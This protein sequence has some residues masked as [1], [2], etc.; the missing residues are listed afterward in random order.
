MTTASESQPVAL[1]TPD[2]SGVPLSRRALREQVELHRIRRWGLAVL[3][4][5]LVALVLWSV[6]EANRA[7]L[8]YDFAGCYQAWYLISHGVLGAAGFWKAQG[9]FIIWPLAIFGLLWPHPITLLVIQDLAIV[10]AEAVAFS[11]LTEIIRAR[12]DL[13]FFALV[14]PRAA[15]PRRRPVDLLVGV[16]GLPLGSRWDA[17]RHPRRAG[18]VAWSQARLDLEWPH[19]PFRDGPCHLPGRNRPR[20]AVQAQATLARLHP[21]RR[22]DRLVPR[23]HQARCG[24]NASPDSCRLF[25]RITTSR[26]PVRDRPCH[27]PPPSWVLR[28]RQPGKPLGRHTGERLSE[29]AARLVHRSLCRRRR[30][31]AR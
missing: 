16:L 18:F 3:A 6:L 1:E 11:W 23:P 15:P 31:G 28:F 13:P 8:G 29:R 24:R 4:V 10:G 27:D 14:E 12:R 30:G 9:I 22:R 17:V 2:A 21:D 19:P 20:P 5:Q 7:V 26:R 25:C